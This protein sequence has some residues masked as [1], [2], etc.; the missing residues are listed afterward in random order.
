[1]E[2]V[3]ENAEDVMNFLVIFHENS[4]VRKIVLMSFQDTNGNFSEIYFVVLL[5]LFLML[6]CCVWHLRNIIN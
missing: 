1:M 3:W 2:D 4:Y 6:V 5:G